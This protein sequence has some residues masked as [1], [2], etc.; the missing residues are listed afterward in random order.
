[1]LSRAL[2]V[3]FL[4]LTVCS[5]SF[6]DFTLPNGVSAGD[7]TGNSAVLWTR[8]TVE[9]KV[10]FEVFTRQPRHK[11]VALAI[12][13]VS[14]VN[15]PVKFKAERLR[16]GTRYFYTVRNAKGDKLTGTF[17]TLDEEHE[18][19]GLDFGVSGD[20]RGE[21]SPYPAIANAWKKKLDFFV[22]L[23]DTI[24]ADYP[25]PAVNKPQ[26]QTLLDF[27]L[28][29]AEVYSTR[30]GMNAWGLLQLFTP[31][32]A[33]IDDHEVNNDFAGGAPAATDERFAEI[34]GL[35]NETQ[36]Y[37]NGL[38]AFNE[39]NAIEALTWPAIGDLRSDNRPDLY[40]LRR[41]DNTA[42]MFMLDARS[43]RDQELP[44]VSNP[45]DPSQVAAYLAMSFDIN[46]LNGQALPPRTLLGQRQLNRL[47]Q[48][49]LTMQN[50][51]VTWKFIMLP[52]P[53]QNIGVIGASD[54]Y[55]GY[56]AERRN[57]LKFIADN[58]ISNVVFVSADIHGTL[59]N[60]LTYQMGPGMAQIPTNAFEITTGSVAFDAPFG[61]TVLE[62]A[63]AVPVAPGVSLLDAFLGQLGLADVAAF[64]ALP[65]AVKNTALEGLVNQQIIPLGYDT[66]GLQDTSNV[67]AVLTKGTYTAVFNFGWTEFNVDEHSQAL[68]VTTYGIDAYTEADLLNDPA[69][70][71][72]RK[73]R[74]INQFVV[75]PQ[76]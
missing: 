45:T 52:E 63:A 12:V 3:L 16:A 72:S 60:N 53:I 18:S 66:L 25:T 58:N 37:K 71:I 67:E 24:Y 23:G 14:D 4:S 33:T 70:I 30:F 76:S 49:L 48:D 7:V 17:K 29:H 43:F 20:W 38:Q 2:A 15:Q 32:Y 42:A 51:G 75:T 27:R 59:V 47:L 31:I 69:E 56:A 22:K 8:S 55:E 21:L 34:S 26:A 5:Q 64:N 39:F 44:P 61:P 68:T 50:A 57:L 28:K 65:Q 35:I 40:R 46:P 10:R 73:P 11:P 13:E 19:E 36:L 41:F 9:G 1:M 74:L 6:A 62:L 54:R